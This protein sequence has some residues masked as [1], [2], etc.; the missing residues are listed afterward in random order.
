MKDLIKQVKK[1]DESGIAIIFSLMM[2]AIF[3]VMG[4]TFSAYMSN[5]RRAAKYQ[6]KMNVAEGI[7]DV[8]VYESRGALL[9]A[10][11]SEWKV[12]NPDTSDQDEV[13]YFTYLDGINYYP[14][15]PEASD[16]SGTFVLF[17]LGSTG[18]TLIS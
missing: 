2:M 12:A 15:M 18:S 17:D 9:A 13:D 14:T 4:M 7:V 1:S 6:E 5:V 8:V 10:F 16:A 3:L 11:P